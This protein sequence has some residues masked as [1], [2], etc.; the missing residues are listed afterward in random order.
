MTL[1]GR[2]PIGLLAVVLLLVLMTLPAAV[3]LADSPT[4]EATGVTATPSAHLRVRSGPDTAFAQVGLLTPGTTV[5]VVGRNT[6]ANWLLVE[7]SPGQQGWIAGWWCVIDGDLNG[8]PLAEDGGASAGGAAPVAAASDVKAFVLTGLNMRSGAGVGY[9]IVGVLP[10]GVTVPV[11]ARH[12][13]YPWVVVEYGGVQGFVNSGFVNLEGNPDLLPRVATLAEVGTVAAPPSPVPVFSGT[14]TGQFYN[15]GPHLKPI[16]WRG[17][18]RGNDPHRVSKIGDSETDTPY[19]LSYLD[20]GFYELASHAYLQDTVDY[21]TYS[22]SW[23]GPGVEEGL[24]AESLLDPLW[25][26]PSVCAPGEHRVACEYRTYRPAVALIL[27]RTNPR[28]GELLTYEASVRE[29]VEI[30][31]ERGV[32]PVLSTVPYSPYN[33]NHVQNE[34]G[35]L[36]RLAGEYNVPLWDLYA[37]TYN[38]PNHGVDNATSHLTVTDNPTHFDD[39]NLATYG[40]VRRNLEALEVLHAIMTQVIEPPGL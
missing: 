12:T 22:F 38:M 11:L 15:I 35:I 27:V 13:V 33:N 19:F 21:F 36:R 40:I 2:K 5:P 26:D 39:G 20:Q 6:A 4:Q 18:A 23:F 29:I 37:T 3:A 10:S 7:F 1:N 9:R 25:A 28:P 8:I 17:R 32:I 31:I 30:S 16:Y 24:I 14:Y 34:N